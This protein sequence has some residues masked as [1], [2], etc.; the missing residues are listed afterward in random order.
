MQPVRSLLVSISLCVAF[1]AFATTAAAQNNSPTTASTAARA[2]DNSGV[3]KRDSS[4][5]ILTPADQPN[6]KADVRLAAAVR[7]AIVR[8]STLSLS[9][10]NVKL[11]AAH[12]A[13]T[14][15]GPV[16]SADE[17]QK[18]EADAKSVSGVHRVDNQLDV[19]NPSGNQP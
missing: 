12:G 8:D 11:I 10:H 3:N 13:V 15:R 1:L 14:L 5:G 17:K 2:S 18:V 16:D 7:R 6:D 9:A 19:K 4:P